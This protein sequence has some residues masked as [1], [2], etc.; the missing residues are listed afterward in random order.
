MKPQPQRA[1]ASETRRLIED[2]N[3]RIKRQQRRI[4]RILVHRE[5]PADEMQTLLD[6]MTRARDIMQAHLDGFEEPAR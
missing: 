5:G 4:E 1:A 6:D 2:M 3:Q